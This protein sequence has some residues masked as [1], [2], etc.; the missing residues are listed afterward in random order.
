MATYKKS[1]SAEEKKQRAEKA[2][3]EL[4]EVTK[5]AMPLIRM[6]QRTPE[7]RIEMLDFMSKMYHYSPTNMAMI[8]SQYE[9][10]LFVGSFASWKAKGFPVA[11]G[12]HGEMIRVY[13]P[14]KYRKEPNGQRTPFSRL[15]QAERAAAIANKAVDEVPFYG[16]GYVFDIT[17]TKAE[18]KDYPKLYPNRPFDMHADNPEEVKVVKKT[19][20]QEIQNMGIKLLKE[21]EYPDSLGAAKGV[22]LY[23]PQNKPFAI[24]MSDRVNDAEYTATLIHELAH[25][26]LHSAEGMGTSKFWSNQKISDKDVR[27]LKELQA[28]LTSYV[29]AKGV[30]I[31]TTERAMPYIHDW[32]KGIDLDSKGN[33]DFQ[34]ELLNDVQGVSKGLLSKIDDN[35]SVSRGQTQ[36]QTAAKNTVKSAGRAAA[37]NSARGMGR[38]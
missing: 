21:S 29:V 17:Q 14:I 15:S 28:E 31:D 19:L 25:A 23:G 8:K 12:Q 6:D 13:T 3:K 24:V 5:K 27:G 18:P 30:G 34:V 7:Q 2:A 9:G 1:Y 36:T 33:D 32:T 4:D 20:Q 16:R 37:V 26:K 35:L 22:T 10:A 11:S 38:A